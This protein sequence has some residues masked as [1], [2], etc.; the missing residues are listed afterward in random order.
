MDGFDAITV[1]LIAAMLILVA[2]KLTTIW[3][4]K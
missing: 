4:K 2:S 1:G 3:R